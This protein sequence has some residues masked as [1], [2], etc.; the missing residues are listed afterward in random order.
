MNCSPDWKKT[1]EFM[2]YAKHHMPLFGI[3]TKCDRF[4]TINWP[5]INILN[6]KTNFIS[7][8]ER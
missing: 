8:Y 2:A 7:L 5:N 6:D 3:R 4:W 1:A